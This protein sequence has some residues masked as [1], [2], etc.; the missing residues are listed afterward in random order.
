MIQKQFIRAII[1]SVIFLF[2]ANY[3][4][5][6]SGSG[7]ESSTGYII[8]YL[9]TH[10]FGALSIRFIFLVLFI[11][12]VQWLDTIIR[13]F[14]IPGVGQFW[15]LVSRNPD[16]AYDWFHQS[17]AWKIFEY[18]PPPDFRQI[19]P[20]CEWAGPFDLYVPAL[21]VRVQIFGRIGQYESTREEF[22]QIINNEKKV[23]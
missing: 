14:K 20:E 15:S 23:V 2:I 6:V 3:F 1:I 16:T 7:D 19:V 11:F 4:I 17:S 8:E 18:P 12:I 9:K 5:R 10:S 21:G 22:M 13:G